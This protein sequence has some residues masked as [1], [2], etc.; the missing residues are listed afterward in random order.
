MYTPFTEERIASLRAHPEFNGVI[1]HGLVTLTGM[2]DEH[3][4]RGGP[5]ITE[6]DDARKV[7]RWIATI[8]GITE[9]TDWLK[10]HGMF[11]T[12]TDNY[13][14]VFAAADIATLREALEARKYTLT[15]AFKAL[16]T[17]ED[18][19]LADFMSR[20]MV[21]HGMPQLLNREGA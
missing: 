8:Y 17:Q 11:V 18:Y 19:E 20:N 15:P 9:F 2:K 14:G 3:A 1:T 10:T 6:M 13:V 12:A 21:L 4:R 7:D 5:F 16:L